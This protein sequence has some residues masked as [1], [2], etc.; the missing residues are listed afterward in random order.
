MKAV[1]WD[2]DGTLVDSEFLHFEALVGAMSSLG[3][4]VPSD[5]HDHVIGMSAE[6]VHDWL[7]E[8]HGLKL[9][10]QAWIVKKY[11]HYLNRVTEITPFEGAIDLWQALETAG[12]EQAT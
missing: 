7:R 11:E 1:L 4:D 2:M 12:V 5:L 6:S 3:L 10:F 8:K 9:G